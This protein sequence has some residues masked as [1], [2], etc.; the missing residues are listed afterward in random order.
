MV[1][2]SQVGPIRSG[3]RTSAHTRRREVL[4]SGTRVNEAVS[5]AFRS[6]FMVTN[7]S[8]RSSVAW[9]VPRGVSPFLLIAKD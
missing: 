5:E 1:R 8:T 7:P 4:P 9:T 6:W 2:G 3:S